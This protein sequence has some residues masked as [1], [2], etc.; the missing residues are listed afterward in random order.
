MLPINL[1]TTGL[2][3]LAALSLFPAGNNS[4]GGRGSGGGG[5]N[6]NNGSE[7]KAQ[8]HYMVDSFVPSERLWPTPPEEKELG[9][10]VGGRDGTSFRP[11][12]PKD[13]Q[14]MAMKNIGLV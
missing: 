1:V 11:R 3:T 4:R 5:G 10:G 12:Q 7:V 14:A 9:G 2:Q 6:S 13:L 8:G